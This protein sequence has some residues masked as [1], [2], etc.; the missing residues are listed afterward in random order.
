M[1]DTWQTCNVTNYKYCSTFTD[2]DLFAEV[3]DFKTAEELEVE[4]LP[5]ELVFMGTTSV[6]HSENIQKSVRPSCVRNIITDDYKLEEMS[7]EVIVHLRLPLHCLISV[8]TS[9]L[10]SCFHV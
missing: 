4:G 10:H 7:D 2:G 8:G 5:D 9:I 1:N 3:L 6:V